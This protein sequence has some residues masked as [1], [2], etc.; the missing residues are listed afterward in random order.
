MPQNIYDDDSFF[1]GYA[2]L[3]RS[4]KGLDAAGEWPALRALLPPMQNL[5]VV[6]LGCGYGWFCRWAREQGAASILG[7]DLSEKMLARAAETTPDP[8][9]TYQRADLSA[10]ILPPASFDLAY[11]SLAPAGRFVF[12]L[13]HPLYMAPTNPAFLTLEDGRRIW[14]LDNYLAEGRRETT[15]FAPGVVK[16]HRTIA[17]TL[18]EAL[19]AGFRLT[20]IQEWGPTD[21]QIAQHPSWADERIR[22]PF[23]LVALAK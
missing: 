7:L 11:S 16:Y 12:S 8:A 15:W 2:T 3:A 6:D 22:P 5:R 1:A 13:E 21:A 17:T 14:P 23:L 9:I 4:Q 20:A 18:T 10:L 19:A